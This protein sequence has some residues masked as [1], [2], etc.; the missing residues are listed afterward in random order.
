MAKLTEAQAAFIRDNAFYGVVTTLRPDGSPHST[1]VWVTEEDGKVLFNTAYPRVKARELERDPRASVVVVDPGNGYRW[2]AVS[3]TVELT[4]DGAKADIDE[5]SRK[6]DG[7]D[8]P[9]HE[10]GESIGETRVTARLT[11]EKI[12]G[13]GV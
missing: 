3:G 12:Q 10:K 4:T 1:V 8:Y 7:I 9:N 11:P 2:V 6:Y 5:L 13:Y